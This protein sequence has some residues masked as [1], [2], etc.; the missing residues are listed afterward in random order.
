MI[1]ISIG[2]S[3]AETVAPAKNY[4]FEAD[5]L[6]SLCRRLQNNGYEFTL[7]NALKHDRTKSFVM[8]LFWKMKKD[9]N[10]IISIIGS[11]GSSKSISGAWIEFLL[12]LFSGMELD[13]MNTVFSLTETKERL[14]DLKKSGKLKGVTIVRD[15]QSEQGGQGMKHDARYEKNI[16]STIRQ[17]K[18]NFIY[19]Y[20]ELVPHNHH[21][22]L[23]TM[24]E[25][26]YANRCAKLI[27]Y[28]K[29]PGFGEFRPIGYIRCYYPPKK[30]L[31][32]YI[33]RK[34]KNI[35]R[36]ILDE[37][38]GRM[39]ILERIA[40]ELSNEPLFFL[41][42]GKKGRMI[43]VK[44]KAEAYTGAEKS[45]ILEMAEE[46]VEKKLPE[47]ES[48]FDAKIYVRKKIKMSDESRKSEID[49]FFI[50][51]FESHPELVVYS[52]D[53][54]SIKYINRA[55][56]IF[57]N[58]MSEPTMKRLHIPSEIMLSRKLEPFINKLKSGEIKIPG[59]N[60]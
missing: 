22:I 20:T 41:A 3:L 40:E 57:S 46:M 45:D 16:D 1:M 38:E 14:A 60:A 25:I 33:E 39:K 35:D 36:L 28:F 27:I 48:K 6:I 32:G 51:L 23:E 53:E 10:A 8:W 5:P 59:V 7:E 47:L 24:G 56:E 49:I 30:I 29:A 4:K 54:N 11:T 50:T 55:V 37:G 2:E 12:L 26:D 58:F 15:E 31:E 43:Q 42:Q 52:R 34:E 44:K 9:L 21:I 19:I 13:N 18:V 17:H